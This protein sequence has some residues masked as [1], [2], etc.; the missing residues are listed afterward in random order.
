MIVPLLLLQTSPY[1][2]VPRTPDGIGVSYYGREIAQVMGHQ[3]ASWLD[4]PERD[5]EEGLGLLV[6]ALDPKPGDVVADIGAGTGTLTF[7]VARRVGAK[8]KVYAVEIQPELLVT[9]GDRA[10][11]YGV[12]NVEGVLGTPVDPK[13]PE[14]KLDLIFLVDV[15]HEFDRPDAMVRKMTEALK[16]G[17]RLVLVE[18]RGEDPRVPIKPLHKM[19]EAQVRKELADFP[20]T[21]VKNDRR[22]PRQ[23]VLVFEKKAAEKK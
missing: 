10:K 11:R 7:P 20:L 1:A 22:L 19:T 2:R 9:I 8:G 5:R 18:Y 3:A 16:P 15:Y 23:H 14:G 13:L 21:F 4:R 12:T 17:G 6:N